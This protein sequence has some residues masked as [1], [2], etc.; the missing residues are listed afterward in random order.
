MNR[1]SRL[2]GRTDRAPAT[3][4]SDHRSVPL[5][6][7]PRAEQQLVD[8][9]VAGQEKAWEELFVRYSDLLQ[10]RIRAILGARSRDA[11]LVEEIAA[12][13]WNTLY[14]KNESLLGRFQAEN[15]QPL[16]TFLGGIARI[17]VL[18]FL[19]SEHRRRCHEM[20]P[21]I[22]QRTAE[23]TDDDG[24]RLIVVGLSEFAEALTPHQRQFLE[25]HLLNGVKHVR[26]SNL[27]AANRW[28]LRHRIRRKLLEFLDRN[29]ERK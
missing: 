13:V 10:V 19:R 12:E 29:Q 16:S 17:E 2:R 23:S 18:R 27:T 6:G 15:G 20:S 8:N 22:I 21:E 26:P 1:K 11:N 14:R 24:H 3:I 28:Q 25:D 5:S 7:N 4:A 9:C